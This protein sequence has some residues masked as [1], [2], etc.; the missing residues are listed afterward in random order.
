METHSHH[1][2]GTM[3][4][5]R[6]ICNG[7]TMVNLLPVCWWDSQLLLGKDLPAAD[8]EPFQRH[9]PRAP[10]PFPDMTTTRVC[11]DSFSVWELFES[12]LWGRTKLFKLTLAKNYFP[13]ML[14]PWLCWNKVPL[15]S[16]SCGRCVCD[17]QYPHNMGAPA[18]FIFQ[19]SSFLQH[20]YNSSLLT[21]NYERY[22][23]HCWMSNRDESRVRKFLQL[24]TT[25][26]FSSLSYYSK[27]CHFLLVLGASS[28]RILLKATLRTVP[29]TGSKQAACCVSPALNRFCLRHQAAVGQ[30]GVFF[31]RTINLSC[32]CHT[33]CHLSSHPSA[34]LSM[35][36]SHGLWGWAISWIAELT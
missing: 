14:L 10:C 33:P 18:F 30:S 4:Y 6:R 27:I 13:D 2:L 25:Q 11:H 5:F 15:C 21:W 28:Q 35:C 3:G 26:H 22:W 7:I 36:Q 20:F 32:P 8:P 9:Q 23:K 12:W 16:G 1:S 24:F 31:S 29:V 19:W 17:T 34:S